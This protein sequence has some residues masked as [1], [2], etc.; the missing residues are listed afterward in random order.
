MTYVLH[1]PDMK[2]GIIFS[3]N[4]WCDCIVRFY[5]FYVFIYLFT[6]FNSIT[7]SKRFFFFFFFFFFSEHIFLGFFNGMFFQNVQRN[8]LALADKAANNVVVV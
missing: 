3:N 1:I 4:N 2:L 8:V 5:V 6:Y 7:F